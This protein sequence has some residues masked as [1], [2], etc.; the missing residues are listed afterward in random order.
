[1][2]STLKQH[3]VANL[4]KEYADRDFDC[5][6]L[7]RIQTFIMIIFV[8]K[9]LKQNHIINRDLNTW[10]STQIKSAEIAK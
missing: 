10:E 6:S 8:K 9:F 7:S 5:Q 1:M 4:T 2:L 3:F